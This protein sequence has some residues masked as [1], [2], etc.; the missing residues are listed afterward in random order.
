MT[1][2]YIMNHFSCLPLIG[3]ENIGATCY[4]NATLQCFCHIQKFVEYFKYNQRP[5]ELT[6]QSRDNLTSSFKLL[7]E[8]LWQDNYDQNKIN[9]SYAP[10]EFKN[11]ISKL[12]PLFDG[13]KANDSKDLVNFIILTLHKELNFVQEEIKI[14]TKVDET[15]QALVFQNFLNCFKMNNQSLISAIFYAFNCNIIQ[16][17]GCQSCS[18]SYQTYFF[19]NFPLEKVRNFKYNGQNGGDIVSLDDCFLYD[20]QINYMFGN[21]AMYCNQCGMIQNKTYCTILTTIPEILIIIL[22]RGHGNEFKI[23]VNFSPEINLYNYVQL[24]NVGY[25]YKLIGV[26]THIGES[27]MGGHFVAYCAD[28]LKN[29]NVWY[30]FND[31]IVSLV[32]DFQK[33]VINFGMPY[34]LFYQKV[35]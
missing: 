33:E 27:G 20:R 7:I 18:Y 6:K 8:K 9:Q 15:N 29:N 12:D 22:N 4:M 32:T 5:I 14:N 1:A 16:C 24:S 23:K 2:P 17:T 25:Y 13:I 11:K 31:S 10:R 34:L 28:M 19:L 35:K 3:L 21:N 30:K 26:I